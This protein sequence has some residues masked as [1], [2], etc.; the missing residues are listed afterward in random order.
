MNKAAL[1]AESEEILDTTTFS[2]LAMVGFVLSFIGIFSL[3]YF[4]AVPFAI[5]G[6]ALGAISL[7]R[8]KN[9]KTGMFSKLMGL[10]A[11]CVGATVVSAGLSTRMLA[12][13]YDLV[14]ARKICDLYLEAL[15]KGQMDRVYFLGGYDPAVINHSDN[16]ETKQILTKLNTDPV[17]VA[18]RSLKTPPNWEFG[19]VVGEYP[20]ENAH[21]YTLRYRNTNQSAGPTY[22]LAVRKNCTKLDRSKPTVNWFVDQLIESKTR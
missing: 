21:T 2:M 12:N 14:H 1:S 15:S 18:I 22:D 8:A 6:V 7:W 19:G 11:V 16:S 9:S 13:D 3:Q 20:Q 5:L 17:Y 4:Q 10:A